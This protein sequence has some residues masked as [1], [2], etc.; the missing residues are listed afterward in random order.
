M[1]HKHSP[2]FCFCGN[3][4]RHLGKTFLNTTLVTFP[5]MNRSRHQY[6]I[7][8]DEAD[9]HTV[10]LNVLSHAMRRR[11]RITIPRLPFLLKHCQIVFSACFISVT[12]FNQ[13][14]FFFNSD[15]WVL[16]LH[17]SVLVTW[18]F[19]CHSSVFDVNIM[20]VFH[21][22]SSFT[23][24]KQRMSSD[25]CSWDKIMHP[26]LFFKRILAFITSQGAVNVWYWTKWT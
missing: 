3:D 24:K 9:Y 12:F 10:C 6:E 5:S 21:S 2:G 25:N 14:L 8:L 17:A 23:L 15:F 22:S 1:S 16:Y 11:N 20:R 7:W 26:S 4:D 18:D 13:S 19:W